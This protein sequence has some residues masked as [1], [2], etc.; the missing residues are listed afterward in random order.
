MVGGLTD[1]GD[2]AHAADFKK[3]RLKVEATLAA[4]LSGFLYAYCRGD[5]YMLNLDL[6]C[7][8][9]LEPLLLSFLCHFASA[10]SSEIHVLFHYPY[11]EIMEIVAIKKHAVFE[12]TDNCNT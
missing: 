7:S 2:P 10:R 9:L 12:Q 4:L 8:V 3:T 6:I 5:L 11:E 1:V